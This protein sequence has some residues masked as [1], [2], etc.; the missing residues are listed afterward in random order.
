MGNPLCP[1]GAGAGPGEEPAIGV[2][3][4]AAKILNAVVQVLLRVPDVVGMLR[5]HRGA[6][7]LGVEGCAACALLEAMGA[8]GR[9]DVVPHLLRFLGPGAGAGGDAPKLDM[10]A[11][12]KALLLTVREAAVRLLRSRL[13]KE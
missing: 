7:A 10:M 13:K 11:A 3:A 12:L 6:C 1:A 9:P 8:F 2:L 4:G 5:S